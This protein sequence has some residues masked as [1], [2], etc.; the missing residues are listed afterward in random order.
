MLFPMPFVL[1][2]LSRLHCE[3]L[4]VSGDILGGP[5]RLDW[6]FSKGVLSAFSEVRDRPQLKFVCS[7]LWLLCCSVRDLLVSSLWLFVLHCNQGAH[8]A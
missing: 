8:V 4:R 3:S 6:R 1:P 5:L 2:L 7:Y